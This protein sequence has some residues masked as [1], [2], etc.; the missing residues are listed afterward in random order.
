MDVRGA[1]M[2]TESPTMIGS[3]ETRWRTGGRYRTD[4]SSKAGLVDETRQ[5]L[6]TIGKVGN[7]GA[8][9]HI[10][11]DGGLSQ[12][13]RS[14][15][16]RI[17][18]ILYTRLVRWRPP[19]WVWED[20][21]QFARDDY[22]PTLQTALLLHVARQ[23]TLLYE[24]VQQVIVPRWYGGERLV[25]RADVRGFL[26]AQAE[27]RPE[28]DTWTRQTREKLAGNVLTILRDYGL[29]RGSFRGNPR[30]QIVEPI[31]PPP[32]AGHL[33]RLLIAEGVGQR[34]LARHPDWRI[35]LWDTRRAEAAVDSIG[36]RIGAQEDR[37]E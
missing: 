2:E 19:G 27:S 26:D 16:E 36:A 28:I 11:I 14:T 18:R 29:L 17:L 12:R 37:R 21:I 31:V 9:R 5:F 24:F 15:R 34:E 35:W 32:V 25:V 8:V 1:S 6:L 4:N 3:H 10:L 13:S 20:L 30:K 33:V 22:E 23:D 7:V